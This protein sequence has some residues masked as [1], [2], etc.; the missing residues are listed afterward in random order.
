MQGIARKYK[1]HG[2]IHVNSYGCKIA[3]IVKLKNLLYL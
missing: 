1:T 3:A 2:K